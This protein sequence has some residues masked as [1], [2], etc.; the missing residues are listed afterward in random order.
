MVGEKISLTG[1]NHGQSGIITEIQG[2]HSVVNRLAAMGVFPGK[3]ITKISDMFWRGPVTI[4]VDRA[5]IA[6]GFGMA[7]KI[8][9]EM[10]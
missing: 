4:E 7:E 5:K 9:V 10:G 2:G 1:M 6:I 8:F 3:K